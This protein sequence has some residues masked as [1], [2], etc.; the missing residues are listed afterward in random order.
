MPKALLLSLVLLLCH[1]TPEPNRQEDIAEETYEEPTE[2][3]APKPPCAIQDSL[4]ASGLV[5]V[6][7]LNPNIGVH[8]RYSVT[9][10][11]LHT[12]LYGCLETAYLQAEAASMLSKAQ[13]FLS[14]IDSSLH[15]L[16]WDAT[17]PRSVQW[18]MWEVLQM[19]LDQKVRFVSN[20][21]NG[22]LH[23][24]GCAVDLTVCNQDNIPLDMGT[25]FDYFG[26]AAGT[27]NEALLVTE[28]LLTQQ[29]LENRRLLRRV[30]RQAGFSMISSEWWHFNAMSREA[31]IA[32]YVIVE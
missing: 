7:V 28:G 20:P 25:D 5:N 11:F 22:S 6:Q 30:M 23:N 24:F 2:V 29:Q 21:R 1:C 3:L 16:I 12:D 14:A 15:L 17:R 19:P 26:R 31:A 32:R 8:L 27:I 18:K 4:S 13:D 9:N 10:N